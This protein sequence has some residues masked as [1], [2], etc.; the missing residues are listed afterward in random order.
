LRGG[1]RI[2]GPA[3]IEEYDSTTYLAP[4]WSLGVEGGLLAL[5][6]TAAR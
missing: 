4:G 2:T 3:L 1:E 6:R 5:A